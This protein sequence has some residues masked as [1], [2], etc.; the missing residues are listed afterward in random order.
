MRKKLLNIVLLNVIVF[1]ALISIHEIVHIT[2]GSC[3][4]CD[5]GKAVILDIGFNGPYAEMV[6]S[7]ISQ[8]VVYISSFIVT[9]C[10]G[11]LFLTLNS[12]GKNLSFVILGL[13]LIFSSVDIG[14]ITLD[15][16]VYP[17]MGSGF[18]L[19]TIGEYY[20]ASSCINENMF[21]DIFELNE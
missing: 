21:L 11:I 12:P 1:F 15:S 17:I 7:N 14:L 20:I 6:C 13:S 9:A 4:G 3:L 19:I 2:V 16:L 5:Y 18:L 10:F 8:F